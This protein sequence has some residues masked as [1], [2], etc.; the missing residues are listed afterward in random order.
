[1]CHAFKAL[2][3][4]SCGYTSWTYPSLGLEL[5]PLETL[6]SRSPDTI[7]YIRPPR[8]PL[9]QL[10]FL[11]RFYLSSLTLLPSHIMNN[12]KVADSVRGSPFR[13]WDA[14]D[15]LFDEAFSRSKSRPLS[16]DIQYPLPPHYPDPHLY[17]HAGATPYASNP[18]AF[19]YSNESLG[20]SGPDEQDIDDPFD[21]IWAEGLRRTRRSTVTKSRTMKRPNR[22]L[23]GSG[24]N[25]TSTSNDASS[26]RPSA[27]SPPPPLPL[28]SAKS[29]RAKKNKS[30]YVYSTL[31]AM[32]FMDA[33]HLGTESPFEIRPM[34]KQ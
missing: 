31:V 30:K 10:C 21:R 25:S 5:D 15:R 29:P 17:A 22:V 32:R 6:L 18:P 27:S 9:T 8:A 12:T 26:S 3:R 28:E 7:L 13:A 33:D 19:R 4:L 20:F 16:P 23:E 11:A 1:M 34:G 2:S 24:S 14:F